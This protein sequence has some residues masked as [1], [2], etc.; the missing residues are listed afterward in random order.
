MEKRQDIQIYI[1][2][3]RK[4]KIEEN[5]LYTGLQIGCDIIHEDIYQ[6]KDNQKIPNLSN[7][8]PL[9]CDSS[10]LYYIWKHLMNNQ[11]KYIGVCNTRRLIEFNENK[12][13]NNIFNKYDIILP[14]KFKTNLINHYKISHN[15]N[16]IDVVCNILSKYYPEYYNMIYKI[17]YIYPYNCFIT[18]K[19][20]FD[21]YCKFFFDIIEKTFNQLNIY[22][23]NSTRNHVINAFKSNEFKC[24]NMKEFKTNE[25]LIRYQMN[26]AGFLNERLLTLFVIKNN[27]S[28]LE[29]TITWKEKYNLFV[30]CNG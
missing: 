22:D 15:S 6:L 23:I 30:N 29:H 9:Y 28:I 7:M 4:S 27:L 11:S 2:S 25:N 19:Y 16:D 13:F 12:E 17:E 20:I 26:I 18:K 24:C 3:H 21:E 8:N 5:S 14:I 1:I 10:G